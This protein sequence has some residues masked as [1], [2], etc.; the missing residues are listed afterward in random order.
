MSANTVAPTTVAYAETLESALDE[1]HGL[2]DRREREHARAGCEFWPAL[3]ST[4]A[5]R[6][7]LRRHNV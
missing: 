6:R 7:I 4:A 2:C 1:I 5:I 3:V